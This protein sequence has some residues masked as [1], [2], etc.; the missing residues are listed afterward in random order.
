[1]FTTHCNLQY[2]PKNCIFTSRKAGQH[3]LL[4]HKKKKKKTFVHLWTS[5]TSLRIPTNFPGWP[6]AFFEKIEYFFEKIEFFFEKFDI[7]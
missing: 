7:F 4:V 3:V 1:M 2:V 5:G 6:P